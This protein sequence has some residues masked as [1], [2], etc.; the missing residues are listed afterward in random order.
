MPTAA[1]PSRLRMQAQPC[2]ADGRT[3]SIEEGRRRAQQKGF[4]DDQLKECLRTYE[5]LNIW[6]LNTVRTRVT[7]VN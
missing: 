7:F 5:D 6:Q 1:S 2:R 4:S 3:R